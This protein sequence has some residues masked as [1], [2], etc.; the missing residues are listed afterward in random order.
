MA[1]KYTDWTEAQLNAEIA[2]ARY[3]IHEYRSR[4]FA[5]TARDCQKELEEVQKEMARRKLRM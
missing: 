5:S 4:G 3:R 1:L 2:T